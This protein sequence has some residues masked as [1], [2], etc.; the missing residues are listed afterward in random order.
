M[1]KEQRSLT[2][3]ITVAETPAAVYAAINDVRGWW[4]GEL[5]GPTDE[6]GGEFTY[7][8]EDIH[9]SKQRVTEL[10]PG[11]RVA[12][13]IVE[14]RLS[15]VKDVHE[16]DGT[17][18]TFDIERKGDQTEVTFTHVGLLPNHGCYGACS[19]AWT[20]YVKDSLRSLITTGKGSPNA[21][22]KSSTT[23]PRV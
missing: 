8:Y 17:T 19:R 15:F 9:Y 3:T 1:T 5:D 14:S 18:V 2:T 16:W 7:R 22:K 20:S 13:L 12:W 6:L 4:S 21:A 11:K 23:S 10:V